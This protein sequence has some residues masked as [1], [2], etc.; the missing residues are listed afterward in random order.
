[1]AKKGRG[2]E[3]GN[4]YVT[5]TPYAPEFGKILEQQ[6][7]PMMEKLGQT[8]GVRF[9]TGFSPS[10]VAQRIGRGLRTGLSSILQGVG[11]HAG[12]LFGESLTGGWERLKSIDQAGAKLRGLGFDTEASAAIMDN[13]LASVKGT[14][15]GMG[16]AA[17][18]AAGAVAAGVKPGAELESVLKGVA[19]AAAA[20]DTSMGDMGAIFN[21]VATTNKATNESLLQVADRGLPIYAKL[22][23]MLGVTTS[24][25]E[26][27]ASRGEIDFATFAE[28]AQA[29]AGTVADE[30]GLTATGSV[31]NFGASLSRFGAELLEGVFAEVGPLFRDL[32]GYVDGATEA[33]KPF[34]EAAGEKLSSALEASMGFIRDTGLPALQGLYDLIVNG[35][36]G[37]KLQEVFGWDE[38]SGVVTLILSLRDTAINA[39]PEVV[40]WLQAL[41]DVLG[42]ALDGLGE[43]L[44]WVTRNKDWLGPLV[45]SVGGFVGALYGIGRA[46][47]ALDGIMKAG[48]L[49]TWLKQAKL[50][51]GLT[52]T[53]TA[54]QTGFNT[55]M[56]LNPIGIVVLA[57]AALV[58]G[59]ILAYNKSETFRNF[60]DKMFAG[61]KNIASTVADWFVND[62]A[63][64][65]Q[66]TWDSI[67]GFFGGARD[68]ISA[69]IDGIKDFFA[70][71]GEAFSA[72]GDRVGDV[73]SSITD[74]FQAAIDWVTG[75]FGPIWDTIEA[76]LTLPIN[77]A[78]TTIGLAWDWVT[79][80]FSA[81]WAWV[82]DK[83]SAAWAGLTDLLS[84]PINAA[85]DWIADT[86]GR[87]VDAF[88]TAW[89]NVSGWVSSK[90]NTLTSTLGSVIDRA[91]DWIAN[92]WDTI[93]KGFGTFWGNVTGWVS[94][95]WSTL[96]GLLRGP[97]DK[98]KEWIDTALDGIKSAFDKAVTFIT[99]TWDKIQEAIKKPIRF[100]LTDV[101]DDGLIAGFNKVA[102]FAGS[103]RLSKVT[104][105][106]FQA[107]GYVDLP[108][109]ASDR[110]PYLGVSPRGLLR[111]E[112]EEFIVNRD[113][114][115]RHR[116]VLEAI[117][118]DRFQDGGFLGSVGSFFSDAIDGLGQL[119]TDPKGFFTS[120]IDRLLGGIADTP[121]LQAMIGVPRKLADM[122]ADWVETQLAKL[123]GGTGGTMPVDG[124][125]T[126]PYGYRN[127]PF[128]GWEMHDGVDIGAAAGTPV[129]AALAGLVSQAGPNGGYGNY[130]HILSGAI[131][132][133]YAHLQ[134]IMTRV[135]AT[136]Q[137]GQVIGTVGST[138]WS[139]GPHLHWGARKNGASVD[140][141]SLVQQ[142]SAGIGP[143]ARGVERWTTTAIQAMK[144]A[145]LPMNY[146]PLLMHRMNVE[147]GGNPHAIN[148]WDSNAA[149]GMPSQGLMQTIPSTFN[150]YAGPL[151]SRGITDPLANIYAAI[152]YSLARYGMAGLN[153]A[154]G[155]TMGYASGTASA[156][157]GLAWV[158]E[159]GPEL[160]D[161]RGGE[162]VWSA[163]QSRDMAALPDRIT[164][165]AEDG[166]MLGVFRTVAGDVVRSALAPASSGALTSRLGGV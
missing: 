53:W 8:S 86:W 88:Q 36:F 31:D 38:D 29:A 28:A 44:G 62:F 136:V 132:M 67:T 14:A 128:A 6:V 25:V 16:E 49:V 20:T 50:A 40:E 65:F 93:V 91:K 112:G 26:K 97:V 142:A 116:G 148:L 144:L 145:G 85:K 90:W 164:L 72:A 57:I 37:P 98:A 10:K 35:N 109:S 54:I 21:K 162:R 63:G 119:L 45:A 124:V 108:W 78:K 1:M 52:K 34:A 61:I 102:D 23:E 79:D 123:F 126:S 151:A 163:R 118:A 83:F 87:I 138:G 41:W 135:G 156:R 5:V 134:D 149:A 19:N 3:V 103:K 139:T 113:A 4:A 66:R 46:K 42:S 64:F 59:L 43:M 111:F 11:Q 7:Q 89:K 84:G 106:G 95:K 81:A 121:I 160:V 32:S 105:P 70:R 15:F 107:G 161:F 13:A 127:G 137:A 60:V 154:W 146:L 58:A 73:W 165:V 69:V 56:N 80:K 104:P 9:N 17:V 51:S 122:I 110:D 18:T 77:L 74:A 131:E 129:R 76:I 75:T 125:I 114:T 2:I 55:V 27:M 117:N 141:L 133:F 130:V 120:L 153:A 143:V 140:P 101:I 166:T 115:R 147:S 47:L 96:T 71:L 159:Q 99:D 94:S 82:S 33:I 150:A 152:R 158:G 39:L 155:G 92:T 12:K 48:S 157:R 24:D 100:I 68:K 30:M 22:S